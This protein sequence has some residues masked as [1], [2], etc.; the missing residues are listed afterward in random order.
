MEDWKIKIVDVGYKLEKDI[1][2]FTKRFDSK[3]EMLGGEIIDNG[4]VP[5][6]PTISLTDQ[7]MIALANALAKEGVNPQKEFT[8]GKLEATEKHLQDMRKLVFKPLPTNPK[9]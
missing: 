2:I 5:P 7:Q 6:K 9:K 3:L 4:A 1:Y 8:V